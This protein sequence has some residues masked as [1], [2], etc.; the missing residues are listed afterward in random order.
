MP[1]ASILTCCSSHATAHHIAWSAE[2]QHPRILEVAN[3]SSTSDRDTRRSSAGSHEASVDAS[4]CRAPSGP[5]TPL[6]KS[7][8]GSIS[9]VFVS[10]C[11][12]ALLSARPA[13]R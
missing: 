1:L 13:E 5:V 6:Q 2:V 9:C 12:I 11:A 8:E 7:S 3:T 4:C 10:L